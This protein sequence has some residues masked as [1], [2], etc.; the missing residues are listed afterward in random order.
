[1]FKNAMEIYTL[2]DKSNCRKCFLPSC[3]AFAGSVFTG[4]KQLS[5]CPNLPPELIR[6]LGGN[7]LATAPFDQ[8]IDGLMGQLQK[9]IQDIDLA[10]RARLI[11]ED[12]A[13]G[14]L[15]LKVLG[16]NFSVDTR[17]VIST[18]IH[19]NPWIAVPAYKYILKGA[20]KEV[21]GNW[22][23]FREL[24]DGREGAGIFTQRCEKPLK[25]LADTY[26]DLFA[27]I[28]HLFSGRQ[29]EN[30]S[31]SDIS[32]VLWPLPRLPM[33]ICY[34]KAET[35]LDSDLKLFF[36][37]TAADNLDTDSLNSL[38]TGFVRMLQRIALRHS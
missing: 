38:T 27:D 24:P 11:G 8:I 10:E 20:K 31:D 30:H 15:T 14:K 34:W 29:I 3:L 21:S 17:G 28:I 5:Q 1:M 37:M 35:D 2:L 33:L 6:R 19:V 26:T 22:V 9:E 7:T 16:K 23:S 25:K 18:E 4:Q 13:D 32:I 36:D 12:F